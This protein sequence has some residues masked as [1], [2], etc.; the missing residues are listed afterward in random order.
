[1]LN[2]LW[3]VLFKRKPEEIAVSVEKDGFGY[4]DYLEVILKNENLSAFARLFFEGYQ[5]YN[6]DED[7]DYKFPK[8]YYGQNMAFFCSDPISLEYFIENGLDCTIKDNDGYSV[9]DWNQTNPKLVRFF[10]E[11]G[12]EL[13]RTI[14]ENAD[15]EF[16]S[17]VLKMSAAIN[18]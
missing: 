17:E 7:E 8:N 13:P 9:L 11:H 18:K 16:K 4:Y 6:E 10:Y 3:E 2:K 5:F 12:V 1:M 14:Y 15:P